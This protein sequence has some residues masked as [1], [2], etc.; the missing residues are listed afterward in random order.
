MSKNSPLACCHYWLTIRGS[1]LTE[2]QVYLWFILSLLVGGAYS[3][4]VLQEAFA[5]PLVIQDDA[6]QHVFWMQRFL[7]PN[8][9]P[10]DPIAD[11]FQA[12]APL[13][14][15]AFY[16]FFAFLGISPILVSKLS[17]PVLNLITMGYGF[18]A[19]LR[20]LPI[21]TAAF[22]SSVLLGQSLGMTRAIVSGT[23]RAFLYPL[24]AAF[25]YY[26]LTESLWPCL[27]AIALQGL[28][29]PATALVMV[30]TLVLGL[31]T[32]GD[33]RIRVSREWSRWRLA[34]AG[35]GVASLVLWP[36][37]AKTAV[38]GPVITAAEARQLPEFLPNGR[39]R[40]FYDDNLAKFWLRGRGGIQL[41]GA[42]TPVTNGVGFL[43]LFLPRMSCRFPLMKFLKPNIHWLGRLVLASFGLFFMAHA[44]LFKL[45]LPSRYTE[46]SLRLVFSLTAGLGLV[47]LL[48]GLWRWAG[49]G[50][51]ILWRWL[52]TLG[53]T[54][55]IG[56][57]LLG[58]PQFVDRFPVTSYR[59]GRASALYE[60]LQTQPR[61]TLTASLAGEINNLPTFAKRSILVGGEYSIPYHWG[62]YGP[63][64]QRTLN[65]ITAQYTTDPK[66]LQRFI[67]DYGVDLWLLDDQA[68]DLNA[69][70]QNGWLR[71]Y[72]P[73]TAQAIATLH[74]GKT[75]T[76]QG[77]IPN[78]TVFQD[79]S[80]QVLDANCIVATLKSQG[81]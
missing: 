5:Q 16:R 63:L 65:L 43:L 13:G 69:L 40:F 51:P 62:Y 4:L 79:Q 41:A 21:P 32:W 19:S 81:F 73:A 52:V 57:A 38:Y 77:A 27:I 8:L 47:I 34:I 45:H 33:G 53:L 15:T 42:L 7:D 36:F 24:L 31:V 49:L 59:V 68:F 3:G 2:P 55:A 29:Y 70:E 54:I 75:P 61:E 9:F 18:A 78:C 23:P 74:Q 44:V 48:D 6:R 80:F 10:E 67:Q 35:L 71:Q 46:H 76:L 39:S 11:Y 37:R 60:F 64:R 25:L 14:Y 50:R 20:L 72:Q 26:L 22:C 66:V 28:F 58:Y 30:G 17:P 56:V 1:K 12:I